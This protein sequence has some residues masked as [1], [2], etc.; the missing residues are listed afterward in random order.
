MQS[1]AWFDLDSHNNSILEL[2]IVS[3]EDVR[4]KIARRFVEPLGHLSTFCEIYCNSSSQ[5]VVFP[6]HPRDLR[7]RAAK[8]LEQAE[9]YDR[10]MSKY[11]PLNGEPAK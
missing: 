10:Q 1:K 11:P 5:Y 9:E 6:I 4:D 3:T 7:D 8:M 2:A